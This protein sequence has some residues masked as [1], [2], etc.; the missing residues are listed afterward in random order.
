MEEKHSRVLAN[1][2]VNSQDR[3]SRHFNFNGINDETKKKFNSKRK[4]SKGSCYPKLQMKYHG[5][6]LVSVN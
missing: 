3:I 4:N 5:K 2:V 1:A 6:L